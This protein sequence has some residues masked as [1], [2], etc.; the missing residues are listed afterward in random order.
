M[1]FWLGEHPGQLQ[2]Q[3]SQEGALH[4]PETPGQEP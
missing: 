1:A 2:E 4:E 3:S